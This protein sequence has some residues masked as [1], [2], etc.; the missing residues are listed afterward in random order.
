MSGVYTTLT[1]A[2]F[3]QDVLQAENPVVVDF[4]ATW[5][6]P[7]L[8]MAPVFESLA[9]EYGDKM[10]FAKIDTDEN[11]DTMARFGIQGIPTLLFFFKG[12]LVEQLVGYRPRNDL[13]QHIEAVLAEVTKT[14]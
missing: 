1:D 2:S 6:Q 10:T 3:D 13:K 14:V 9:T 8:M 12:Q 5:C 4:W 7:C 11:E